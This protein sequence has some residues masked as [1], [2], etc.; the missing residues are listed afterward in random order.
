MQRP[1]ADNNGM[2]RCFADS[3]NREK[4]IEL[5]P[6]R[7]MQTLHHAAVTGCPNVVEATITHIVRCIVILIL[8]F[9]RLAYMVMVDELHQ[10]Y[11]NWV[12]DRSVAVPDMP[13]LF[14]TLS[15]YV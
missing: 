14:Q 10:K 7:R 5:V 12:L 8:D 11:Y 13:V 3:S 2:Q 1:N 4:F 15:R 9:V 6:R